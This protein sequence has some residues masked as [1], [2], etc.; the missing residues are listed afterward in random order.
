MQCVCWKE[1]VPLLVALHGLHCNPTHIMN[2]DGL[3]SE[4][5]RRTVPCVHSAAQP[6][7][8]LLLCVVRKWKSR[9]CW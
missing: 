7:L 3:L 6:S 1:Q 8:T 2:F 9:G 5:D 4:A